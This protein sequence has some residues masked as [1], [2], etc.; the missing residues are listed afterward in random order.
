M[1]T[2]GLVFCVEDLRLAAH[3]QLP[4]SASASKRNRRKKRKQQL[5][6]RE[7]EANGYEKGG[8]R[9]EKGFGGR[10][11]GVRLKPGLRGGGGGEGVR[12]EEARFHCRTLG[13]IYGFTQTNPPYDKKKWVSLGRGLRGGE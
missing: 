13:L 12:L 2:N 1:R 8:R 6:W 4:L 11:G 9:R 3:R 7:S 10:G 5:Q